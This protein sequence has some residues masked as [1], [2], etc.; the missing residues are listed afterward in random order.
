MLENIN[1]DENGLIPAIV[2]DAVSG[3]ILMLAYMNEEAL[4]KTVDTKETW[5]YS[6]SRKE[7][8]NKGATSGNKQKVKS[9]ALDCDQD[10]LLVTVEPLGPA[11]HTGEESCFFANV[12][13]E[14]HLN[15][16]VI[17]TII[18]VIEERKN[19]PV[20]GSY[21]TYLFNEG[22]D[23]VLKKVG[24]EAS[25]VIIGAK[26]NDKEEIKWEMADLVYH[27][28]V[29]MNMTGVTISDIKDV[30][31]ERHINKKEDAND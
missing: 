16:D 8:W 2:Q 20:E 6:R 5:F 7:L 29:L 27:T 25:E 10:A 22:M 13:N 30:L 11:C 28:L 18:D 12:Y 17:H 3:K 4:Q 1:Y 24:E 9:I 15:R 31:Y 26:N 23:K 14:K 19:N 21:T